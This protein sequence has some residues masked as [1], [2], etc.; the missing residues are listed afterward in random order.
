VTRR[1]VQRVTSDGSQKH[2]EQQVYIG[3]KQTVCTLPADGPRVICTARAVRDAWADG[4][5]NLLQ[6]N[7]TSPTDRTTNAQEQATN[8]TNTGPRRLSAPT[9]QTMRQVRTEELEPETRSQ[10]LLSIHGSPKRLKLLRQDLG[11]M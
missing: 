11:K 7:A 3:E 8:W 5:R 2:P 6:P 10:P 4:P 1:T 9:R